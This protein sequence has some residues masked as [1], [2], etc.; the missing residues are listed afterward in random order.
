[1]LRAVIFDLYDTLIDYDD[2]TSRSFSDS[3]A[4]TLGRSPD[5]FART[6]REG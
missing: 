2:A 3:I 6:W 1:M 5:E 4:A